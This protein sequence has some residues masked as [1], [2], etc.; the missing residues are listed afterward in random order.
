MLVFVRKPDAETN[1][2]H[3][4]LKDHWTYVGDVEVVCFQCFLRLEKEKEPEEWRTQ[5]I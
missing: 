3:Q 5:H 2:G 1:K 4:E